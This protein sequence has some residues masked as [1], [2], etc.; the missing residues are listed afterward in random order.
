MVVDCRRRRHSH[1]LVIVISNFHSQL[2]GSIHSETL[3][4]FHWLLST[5]PYWVTFSCYYPL[6]TTVQV[7]LY[8]QFGLL[9]FWLQFPCWSQVL[10]DCIFK[11]YVSSFHFP[12]FLYLATLAIFASY[13]I[14][15]NPHHILQSS[16]W[17]L[18]STYLP[19]LLCHSIAQR[20]TLLS[21]NWLSTLT[22][23]E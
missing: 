16:L 6:S 15:Q 13:L 11:T 12:T 7:S 4:R 19:S 1:H 18:F 21:C 23:K 22:S 3:Y 9:P 14:Q 20:P 2:S 17:I 10:T 8:Q 5:V